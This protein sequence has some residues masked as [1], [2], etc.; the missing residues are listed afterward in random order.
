MTAQ[1]FMDQQEL[2]QMEALIKR[3]QQT[4]V[5]VGQALAAIR[6]RRGYRLAGFITFEAYLQVRWGWSRQHGYQLMQADDVVADLG[7]DREMYTRVV[8]PTEGHA[9]A[10]AP[11]APTERRTII[12]QLGDLGQYST[13]EL[14]QAVRTVK[15]SIGARPVLRRDTPTLA[16]IPCALDA[17]DRT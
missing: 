15:A 16:P 14:H 3:G 8:I 10:L 13:R 17:D 2:A 1:Q 6:D 12:E 4:F 11:M 9:R 5:E 7:Q